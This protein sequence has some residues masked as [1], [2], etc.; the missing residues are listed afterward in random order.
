VEKEMSNESLPRPKRRRLWT[1]LLVLGI[2]VCGMVTGGGLT[3]K[4]IS[5][6]I[7]DATHNPS[8]M[9]ERITGRMTRYLDL[10]DMQSARVEKT[11]KQNLADLQPLRTEVRSRLIRQMEKTRQEIVPLL[12]PEQVEKLDKRIR[13]LRKFWLQQP[14]E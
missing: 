9:S 13:R 11:I 10:N 8:E 1:I 2:F 4:I 14:T 7:Q 3:L 12:T 5:V 6:R